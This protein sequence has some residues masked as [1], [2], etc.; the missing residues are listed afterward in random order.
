MGERSFV[1]L[2]RG[3]LPRWSR[4][5]APEAIV[6]VAIVG[7]A[8]R[9]P[10]GTSIP[11]AVSRLLAGER[12]AV[13]GPRTVGYAVQLAAPILDEPARS[14]QAKF[15]RRMGLFGLEVAH[16]AFT[17]SKIAKGDRFGLFAGV[18]GLRA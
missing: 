16:E 8:W 15:L 3:N 14:K 4:V 17:A 18:G 9:T 1:H 11:G 7:Q 6:R 10:L 5:V 2:A 13:A 12:A